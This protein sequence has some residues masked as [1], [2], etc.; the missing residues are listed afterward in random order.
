MSTSS[1]N[2]KF[3]FW[4]STSNIKPLKLKRNNSGQVLPAIRELM[5]H[6]ARGNRKQGFASPN[7]LSTLIE[8]SEQGMTDGL[9]P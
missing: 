6:K 9:V 5:A 1:P 8:Q 2:N 3:E 7:V 4:E